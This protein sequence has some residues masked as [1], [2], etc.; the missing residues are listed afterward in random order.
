MNLSMDQV[1]RMQAETI[2]EQQD[3]ILAMQDDADRLNWLEEHPAWRLEMRK[4]RWSCVALTNYEYLTFKT[5]REA[6]DNA[7]KELNK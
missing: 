1:I 5:P 7:M 6:I 2:Q 4:Q 3:I